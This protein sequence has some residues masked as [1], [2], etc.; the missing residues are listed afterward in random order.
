MTIDA[1]RVIPRDLEEEMKESYTNYA[2]SVIVSRALPDARDGLKP[3]Q[4]RILVAMNDLRLAPGSKHRKC[5]KIAGDTSGNYHPHG[6]Q[7]VY[8]TLVRMAQ[9]FNMRSPLIDG[10]GNFGSLDGD[11]PAA[12]RYTEA[13]LSHAAM[14]MLEDLDKRTVDFVA[15]YDETLQEPTVL[16]GRFPNLICNGSSG[17]A[18]GMATNIPPHNLREVAAAVR[19]VIENPGLATDEIMKVLPGPDF[20]T[21]G[22]IY[23]LDGIRRAYARGRGHI[24]LRGRVAV[25]S[26]KGGRESLV[27]TEIPYMVN[28]AGLIETIAGLVRDKTVEG[29][30]DIRDESDK[31]GMRVVVDLR[32]GEDAQIV[33]NQ[34]YKHTPLQSTFGIIL[35]ALDRGQPRVMGMRQLIQCHVDHRKDVV[36]RRTRFELGQAEAR[37]HIL[38]GFKIAL[39]HIDEVIAIIKGAKDRADARR[40]LL[41]RFPL[42]EVQVN[43][44]LDLRLYQ[45]TGLEV[46]KVEREYVELVKRIAQLRAILDSERKVLG[47]VVAEL[48]ELAGRLGDDRRTEI[49]GAGVELRIEDLIA[50]EAYLV[51]IT[52]AGY[53]KRVSTD[54]YRAQ[55]RGGRGVTGMET[56]EEDFVEHLF[57]VSAHDYLLF[58][59]EKGTVH[60]L[61]AYE[62]PEAS[63]Q[64]RGKSIANLLR[65]PADDRV[66]GM[67][68]VR[69][70]AEGRSIM[71]A[72]ERGLVKKTALTSF[73]NPRKGGIIAIGVDDGDRVIAARLT[74]G[75][76]EIVL[77]TR[78]GQSVR[79]IEREVREMGRSARGVRGID[80][81]EGDRVVGME[82]VDETASLLVVTEKGFGKRTPFAQYRRQAR[83]GKGII[84]MRTGERNG[85][86]VAALSVREDDELMLTTAGGM[87]VR[88]RVREIP[89]IG[90]ATQGVHVVRMDDGD[91]LS[92][93]VK[94]IG[95]EEN[96]EEAGGRAAD[97]APGGE[98]DQGGKDRQ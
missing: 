55:R 77:A 13:R 68:R 8:P 30:S 98:G 14:A 22:I 32:R 15:N 12:M 90:R 62:I 74:E 36:V 29:I 95:E 85:R 53:T 5:A 63:R 42:S 97:A 56:K 35:L 18:V 86:L 26:H 44:I 67:V 4:R 93:V 70:F 71:M 69:E 50:D 40:A 37:A 76:N 9:D 92:S 51:T 64:A 91:R 57:S 25:E 96:G 48:D 17:I 65:I 45:L 33:L 78:N 87:M 3:S 80:L 31:E 39:A 19:R 72:T 24:Q 43:A 11:P 2:M 54:A 59:T 41:S 6:E 75:H 21:G 46:E 28:K 49:V 60:W 81:R 52:H 83:G 1:G 88:T 58:F 10:Q 34:L 84:A 89:V 16:P 47:I 94:M 27:I 82:I 66:A 20:P 79:F 23:G 61:K 7:V 73:S 38:E